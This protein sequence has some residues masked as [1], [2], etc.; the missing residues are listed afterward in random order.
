MQLSLETQ[1]RKYLN[2]ANSCG[3]PE[4][5]VSLLHPVLTWKGRF[6]QLFHTI[7]KKLYLL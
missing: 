2:T 6:K 4:G 7:S 5:K 3:K 1:K